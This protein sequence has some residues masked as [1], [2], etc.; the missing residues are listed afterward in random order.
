MIDII[1]H[2]ST[3]R[4]V[5]LTAR[6]Y[7]WR[8]GRGLELQYV[9]NAV[10]LCAM[11]RLELRSLQR[12][13]DWHTMRGKK[14]RECRRV[15]HTSRYRTPAYIYIHTIIRQLHSLI[16]KWAVVNSRGQRV[17]GGIKPGQ[18]ATLSQRKT[19]ITARIQSCGWCRVPT[20]PNMHSSASGD[21]THRKVPDVLQV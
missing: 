20:R 2:M 12:D 17:R 14:K 8:A 3:E 10:K 5:R 21:G 6:V 13:C 9:A 16:V 15:N 18:A 19:T 7:S 1:L 11:V 4:N